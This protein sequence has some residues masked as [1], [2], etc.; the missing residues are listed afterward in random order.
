MEMEEKAEHLIE[1]CKIQMDHFRQTRDLEFKV[2][3]ALWTLI[4]IGIKF[5]YDYNFKLDNFLKL[6][7]YIIFA[8]IIIL[9]HWFCWLKPIQQSE[10]N[11]LKFIYSCRDSIAPNQIVRVV[12]DGNS[13]NKWRYFEVAITLLLIVVGILLSLSKPLVSSENIIRSSI[14]K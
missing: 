10:E 5:L 11:D 12:Q 1:L 2:N 6:L 3:L 9:V 7:C 13:S 4:V 14:I 8:L